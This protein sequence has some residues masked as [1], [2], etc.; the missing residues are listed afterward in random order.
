MVSEPKALAI[1]LARA[2]SNGVPR[3]NTVDCICA[4]RPLI[5]WTIEDALD[6]QL[7]ARTVVSTNDPATVLH[8]QA[9]WP[10]VLIDKRPERLAGPNVSSEAAMEPIIA[11]HSDFNLVV[12]LQLTSPVRTGKDVD[13][14]IALLR[15]AKANS[16]V[17]VVASHALLWD[18]DG[19]RP[20]APSYIIERRPFKQDLLF[21]Q[22]E[23]NGSIYVFTRDY[24]E[25]T[26]NRLG[27]RV[28]LFA[29]PEETRLQVDS[30]LDLFLIER[31]LERERVLAGQ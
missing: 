31:L 14:A 20:P 3:K 28:V 11:A 7:V 15:E 8:L 23:E 4:G 5:D 27:G 2:G 6:A 24:W 19:T 12:L 9:H 13:D 18:Y 21:H 1:I 10:D 30:P 17:S 22:W 29:M 26:R 25:R 16:L